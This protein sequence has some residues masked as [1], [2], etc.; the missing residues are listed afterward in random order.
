MAN[1]WKVRHLKRGDC[2]IYVVCVELCLKTATRMGWK[3]EMMLYM[4]D[5][6]E[7]RHIEH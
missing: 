4:S 5:Y 2:E 3:E 7:V 1:Y 6:V